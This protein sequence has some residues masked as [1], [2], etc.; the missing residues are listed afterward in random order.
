MRIH[1]DEPIAIRDYIE[2]HRNFTLEDEEPTFKNYIGR[3]TKFIPADAS[4]K[5][6]EIGVDT[7]WFPILRKS[8]GLSRKGLD[9]SP[10]LLE[11]RWPYARSSESSRIWNYQIL[12]STIEDGNGT[13]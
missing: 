12:K 6:L 1:D 3:I 4:T 13:T 7:A 5:M 2:K 11:L 10:H 8:K 9:I